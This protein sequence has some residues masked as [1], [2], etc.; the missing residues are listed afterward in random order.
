MYRWY[1][2][3]DVCYAYLAD[4]PDVAT[5]QDLGGSSNN[6]DALNWTG[7]LLPAHVG[8]PADGRYRK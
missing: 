3:A 4:M 8:S 1:K 6:E 5:S 2:D 7:T